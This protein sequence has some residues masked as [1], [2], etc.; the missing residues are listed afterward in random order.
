MV[1]RQ[2]ANSK[3]LWSFVVAGE[4]L[5]DGV[6]DELTGIGSWLAGL[7]LFVVLVVV[8]IVVVV[9]VVVVAVV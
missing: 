9:V 7:L 1:R 3:E 2:K 8:V 4:K 5:E 6:G